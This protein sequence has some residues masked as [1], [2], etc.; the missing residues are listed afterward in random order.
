MHIAVPLE[1]APLP[2][3]HSSTAH[4]WLPANT[5]HSRSQG[6]PCP[7]ACGVR[8]IVVDLHSQGNKKRKTTERKKKQNKSGS[9]I[10]LF[11][12]RKC[13]PM[14]LRLKQQP[15]ARAAVV[16]TAEMESNH[17]QG[18]SL[19]ARARLTANANNTK[20]GE[21][22]GEGRGGEDDFWKMGQQRFSACSDC[23]E[24][25]RNGDR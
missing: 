9:W 13:S 8:K 23:V 12:G 7:G 11:V 22:G 1:T 21:E 16:S 24:G 14:A 5:R 15:C 6:A 25:Q 19:Q 20:K 18:Q 4:S 17:L 2:I 10:S 3:V